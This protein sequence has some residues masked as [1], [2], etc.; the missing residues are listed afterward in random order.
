MA[1]LQ[2]CN[3]NGKIEFFP[4]VKIGFEARPIEGKEV[5]VEGSVAQ[6]FFHFL[7]QSV[8]RKRIERLYDLQGICVRDDG[9]ELLSAFIPP[10]HLKMLIKDFGDELTYVVTAV[11]EW[12]S[13]GC[14]EVI[15]HL[16]E[17]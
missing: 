4:Y 7:S 13:L 14:N 6:K 3:P 11:S 8:W 2:Q 9:V 16:E 15:L 12:E 5:V 10:H 17:S 1:T